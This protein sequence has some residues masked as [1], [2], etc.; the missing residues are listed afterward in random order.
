MLDVEST[1]ANTGSRSNVTF[2]RLSQA[3]EAGASGVGRVYGPCAAYF[4]PA[5]LARQICKIWS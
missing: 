5:I 3:R 1:R 2:Y 4:C